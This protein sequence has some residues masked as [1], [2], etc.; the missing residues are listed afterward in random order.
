MGRV[1]RY[2]IIWYEFDGIQYKIEKPVY[3]NLKSLIID[4]VFEIVAHYRRFHIT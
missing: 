2:L 3:A 4:T 1:V